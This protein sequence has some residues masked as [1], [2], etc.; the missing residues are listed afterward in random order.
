MGN[1]PVKSR[2]TQLYEFPINEVIDECCRRYDNIC[3]V[4]EGDTLYGDIINNMSKDSVCI[5]IWDRMI[6]GKVSPSFNSRSSIINRINANSFVDYGGMYNSAGI[7]SDILAFQ[8]LSKAK[9]KTI[10]LIQ[11]GLLLDDLWRLFMQ[12]YIEKYKLAEKVLILKFNH[13]DCTAKTDFQSVRIQGSYKAFCEVICK[14]NR[15][16]LEQ[17]GIDDETVDFFLDI[18][19]HTSKVAKYIR[20]KLIDEENL[21]SSYL[22][23]LKDNKINKFGL[24]EAD[25]YKLVYDE[26]VRRKEL[27]LANKFAKTWKL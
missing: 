17:F 24:T 13:V 2:G 25:F 5:P 20:E 11:W 14:R 12:A 7:V 9:S 22:N 23:Y 16:S 4:A 19:S 3:F 26:M 8:K 18:N 10:I 27:K 21:S 1:S 6:Y 15:T